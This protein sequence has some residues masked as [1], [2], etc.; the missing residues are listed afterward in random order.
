MSFFRIREP[1]GRCQSSVWVETFAK[2]EIIYP[3]FRAIFKHV[4]T[5]LWEQK[6][7]VLQRR[8]TFVGNVVAVNIRCTAIHDT[9]RAKWQGRVRA[10]LKGFPG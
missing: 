7:N 3:L 2:C 6:K 10:D 8:S 5:E 1:M 9:V 4:T